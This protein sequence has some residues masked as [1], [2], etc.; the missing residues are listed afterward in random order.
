MHNAHTSFGIYTENQFPHP[1]KLQAWCPTADLLALVSLENDLEMYRLSWEKHWSIRVKEPPKKTGGV[2]RISSGSEADVVSLAWRPDGRLI[3]HINIYDYMDGSLAHT[4][5]SVA[6]ENSPLAS[7]QCLKWTEVYLGPSSAPAFFGIRQ[8]PNTLLDAMP[9]LSPIPES[10]TAQEMSARMMFA[11]HRR[12]AARGGFGGMASRTVAGSAL[13][14]SKAEDVT[15]LD[16]ES[17]PIMNALFSSDSHGRFR[18]RLFGGFDMESISLSEMLQMFAPHQFQTVDI[19]AA[20]IQAD[21]SE[22][23][24]IA[25]G[26]TSDA[27]STGGQLL[28]ITVGSELLRRHAREIRAIGVRTRPIQH[29]LAYMD[30]CLEVMK[31]DYGKLCQLS[32]HCMESVQECLKNNGDSNDPTAE[33]SHLLLTGRPSVSMDQYLQQELGHHGVKRW[34]KS[35]KAAYENLRKVAF[36][37]LLPACER[38]VVHMTDIL[39]YSRWRERYGTLD[40]DERKV[41]S[42]IR[43]AGEFIGMIER[44]FQALK[45]EIKQFNEFEN[46]IEQVVERLQPTTRGVDEQA[47]EGPKKFPPV[48]T[49][50][51]AGYLRSGMGKGLAT[52]FK[53]SEATVIGD[54]RRAPPASGDAVPSYPIVYPF[55]QDL[56]DLTVP[57]RELSRATYGLGL[58]GASDPT[59]AKNQDQ[60]STMTVEGHL[61]QLTHQ[62]HLIFEGPSLAVARSFKVLHSLDL[63]SLDSAPSTSNILAQDAIKIALRYCYQIQK[64]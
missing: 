60:D 50:S 47:D 51:V 37:C 28:Q 44:L 6:L 49:V 11:R 54:S 4:I 17:S 7:I 36:E 35:G 59:M 26:T 12:G 32:E 10:S 55:A 42:C 31:K 23:A 24:I 27:K 48:D 62:C 15:V 25:L 5:A 21:L 58:V 52:F 45:F 2:S 20:D 38:L 56:R 63:A 1:H 19:I 64:V 16:E 34:D 40:L 3:G 41:Y 8:S 14:L 33:F 61:M 13:G 18:L 57:E 22:L 39:A 29:L 46:W 53:E 30:E 9:L 43:L